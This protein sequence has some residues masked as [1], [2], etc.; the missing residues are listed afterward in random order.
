VV[1]EAVH[2]NHHRLLHLVRH[3]DPHDRLH[4]RSPGGSDSL[5]ST[6][7]RIPRAAPLLGG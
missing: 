2:R 5:S 6:T 4:F 1:E 7:D 3:H